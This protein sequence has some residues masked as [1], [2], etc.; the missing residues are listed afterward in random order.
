M[1][2]HAITAL[3]FDKRGRVLSVGQNDYLRSHPL[4]AKCAKAVGEPERIFI[5]AEIA[6]LVKLRDWSKAH[7]IVVTR[8]TKDGQ[9]A[10]AKPCRACLHALNLA[11]IKNVVH[12]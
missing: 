1:G 8:Y 10:N 6:A 12:T 4:Q 3:I 2:K 7:K 5:H 9:P 11:N